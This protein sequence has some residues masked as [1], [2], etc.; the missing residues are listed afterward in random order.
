M[1][2]RS[3]GRERGADAARRVRD[4]QR[5]R[6]E[7]V[8]HANR[9]PRE[10]RR[11]A[12][13]HV[14]A[15]RERDDG[16]TPEPADDHATGVADDGGGGKAGDLGEGD[17][18][19]ILDAAR[20]PA[21]ARAEHDRRA[22]DRRRR[23]RSTDRRP[24][25]SAAA[26]APNGEPSITTRLARGATRSRR[27]RAPRGRSRSGC[28]RKA[29]SKPLIAICASSSNVKSSDCA[30][31]TY[32][33]VRVVPLMSRLSVLSTTLRP[34]SKYSRNGCVGVRLGRR[35]SARCS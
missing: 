6:A 27:W 10:C 34:R 20:E 33:S 4:E 5:P 18:A 16:P 13:V 9:K 3:P 32:S 19:R 8:E 12:L 28:G 23:V 2:I 35:A 30:A 15:S 14:E 26:R 31:C 1:I 17:V 11:V 21:E 7:R 22:P 29:L 25:A 24:R